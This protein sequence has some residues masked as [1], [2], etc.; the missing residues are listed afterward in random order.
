LL[1]HSF[2]EPS[3]ALLRW[4]EC[5]HV[6]GVPIE[7]IG[8]SQDGPAPSE[9]RRERSPPHAGSLAETANCPPAFVNPPLLPL[10]GLE[11]SVSRERVISFRYPSR[12]EGILRGV[13]LLP[14]IQSACGR[15]EFVDLSAWDNH[16]SAAPSR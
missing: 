6:R 12:L 14:L 11:A 1:A 5:C 3:S 7:P 4:H 16:P 8:N 13:P 2:E 9:F 10:T 15:V